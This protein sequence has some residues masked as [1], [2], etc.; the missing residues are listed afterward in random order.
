MVPNER[1]EAAF[2]KALKD[3]LDSL[4]LSRTKAADLAFFVTSDELIEREGI[5]G[6]VFRRFAPP[7]G[8]LASAPDLSAGRRS[9]IELPV[10]P[11]DPTTWP[12]VSGANGG[13]REALQPSAGLPALPIRWAS[14][15]MIPAA[16]QSR[17]L[18]K[19]VR[20]RETTGSAGVVTSRN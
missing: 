8:G 12:S 17:R 4:E 3:L 6:R 18:L 15:R 1:R 10:A 14:R 2:D 16:G 9:L 19:A 11:G 13:I 7:P 5:L 20:R